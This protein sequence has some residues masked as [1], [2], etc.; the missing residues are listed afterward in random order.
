LNRQHKRY[1]LKLDRIEL[2]LPELT[3][4]VGQVALVIEIGGALVRVNTI[5]PV[6]LGMLPDSYAGF[7]T[8]LKRAAIEFDVDLTPRQTTDPNADVRMIHRLGRWTLERGD[9]RTHWEASLGA[10]NRIEPIPAEEAARALLWK[11]LFF[12][13]HEV[14]STF[15]S[16]FEF[17]RRV[18]ISRLTF[19]PYS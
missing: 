13:E 10:G 16:A 17:V 15:H 2:S 19:V 14:L 11:L 5:D 4:D 9:F 6:F 3:T 1:G 7:V 18:P 8:S 12:A